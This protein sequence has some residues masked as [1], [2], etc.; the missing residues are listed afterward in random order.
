VVVQKSIPIGE[1]QDS[2][3][4]AIDP[5][6]QTPVDDWGDDTSR[7]ITGS[8]LDPALVLTEA[9]RRFSLETFPFRHWGT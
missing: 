6:G 8:A 2:T 3:F 7:P 5:P 4:A 1:A 9:S